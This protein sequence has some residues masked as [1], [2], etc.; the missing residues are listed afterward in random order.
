MTGDSFPILIPKADVVAQRIRQNLNG[1][2]RDLLRR[3]VEAI[4][5]MNGRRCSVDATGMDE[6]II[7]H[8]MDRL[9]EQGWVAK[10]WLGSQQDRANVIQIEL[11]KSAESQRR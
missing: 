11:P 4:E 3:C 2:S 7:D 5:Q 6:K 8:V 9:R 1:E 10:R